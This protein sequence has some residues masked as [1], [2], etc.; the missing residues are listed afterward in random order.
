MI[1][2]LRQKFS[3]VA[4]VPGTVF[5]A[6]GRINLIGEHTD[7]SGGFVLP[8]SIG[9]GTW[10]A[11]APR[12]DRQIRVHSEAQHETAVFS[13]ETLRRSDV[14]HWSR[15]VEGI[16]WALQR[17][18]RFIQGADLLI[19]SS[20]PLGSGLS[21]S[22]SLEVAV[23][24]ALLGTTEPNIP[25]MQ[26]AQIC[27]SAENDFVGARCGLM[28][29]FAA[30]HGLRDHALLF[31]CSTLEWRPV[32]L[33][34]K[35]RWVVANTM[36]RHSLASGEYNVRRAEVEALQDKLHRE[37]P[38]C[39]QLH[40]LHDA[41]L[42]RFAAGLSARLRKRLRH[43]VGEN[44]RVLEFV[45]HLQH[46]DMAAAGR[47]LN[48]SH[49]S[50]R[51]D[52]EVSCGELDTMVALAGRIPGVLGA[53][54]LGGGFGGCALALVEAGQVDSF[55]GGLQEAYARSTGIDAWIHVCDIEQGARRIA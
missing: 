30:T 32:A 55:V 52:F 36:V 26:L 24:L 54:M 43:I 11:A 29:Q 25:P 35:Y 5:F 38:H 3:A 45:A 22:A 40:R 28:D 17:Q 49:Q 10:V 4:G 15:Y 1:A 9:L 27:Q 20:L 44:A 34:E 53:R 2:E 50:L 16:A 7:Y 48:A 8:A 31:N 23:A 42:T 19:A 37:L 12:N 33:P 41:D 21:S 14:F 13:L 18:G 47:L 51:D 46:G 6:P 39:A